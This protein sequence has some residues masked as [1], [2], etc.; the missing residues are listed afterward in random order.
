[1]AQPVRILGIPGSL[2]KASYTRGALRAAQQLCP[3]G[4]SIEMFELD[5]PGL[6]SGRGAV[7]APEGG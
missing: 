5:G 6:Q 1:M 4:A 7:C 3:E 2:R